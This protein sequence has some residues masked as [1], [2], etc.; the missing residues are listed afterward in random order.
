MMISTTVPPR[1]ADFT[2][3]CYHCHIIQKRRSRA[4]NIAEAHAGHLLRGARAARWFV[5][6]QLRA[7]AD[8]GSGVQPVARASRHDPRRASWRDGAVPD[9]CGTRRRAARAAYPAPA[10]DPLRPA[11]L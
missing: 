5:R 10:W 3:P 9:A 1:W 8:T 7:P 4:A 6:H 11:W 2:P